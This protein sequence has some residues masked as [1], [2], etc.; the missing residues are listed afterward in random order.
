MIMQSNISGQT[1]EITEDLGDP[2]THFRYK[3]LCGISVKCEQ[4]KDSLLLMKETNSEQLCHDQSMICG[5]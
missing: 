5:Q 3:G 4:V 1:S 2:Y